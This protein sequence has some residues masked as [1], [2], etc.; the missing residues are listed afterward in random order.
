MGIRRWLAVC[1]LFLLACGGSA[2]RDWV[3]HHPDDPAEAPQVVV[4]A[5]TPP[6]PP[7][8]LEGEPF[9]VDTE[10]SFVSMTDPG[11]LPSLKVAT[12][13]GDQLLPLKH[14]HVTAHLLGFVASVQVEQ[15]YENPFDE[16]I[17]V[18]YVFPLPENSAVG[19]MEMHIGDRVIAA[20]IDERSR[21]RK[22]YEAAKRQ[23][24]TTALLEQ[25]RPNVFTQHVANIA[26]GEKIDVD[27]TYVQ[28]LSYDLGSYEFVF[29][30]VVG[31]RFMPGRTQPQPQTGTGTH[32]D[33][34]EVPDASRISP[35][36]LGRG[37]RSGHDI[38]IE[39]IA[40]AALPIISHSVP[41]HE[42]AARQPADGSLRLTLAEKESIPN[43]DF[44]LRYRVAGKQPLASLVTSG[45]DDDGYFALVIHP[46]AL[47]VDELVGR[48]ELIFVLDVSGSM[49]GRPLGLSKMAM[50]K[51]LA[52]L[53]PH[54]TFDIV[55]FAGS[56]RRLFKA[57]RPANRTNVAQALQF[58]DGLS[59]GGGT[60]MASAVQTALG[61]EVAPGRNRYVFFLTDGYVGNEDEIFRGSAELV[62]TLKERGQR[63]RVF[64]FG[65]GSSPNRHLL[66]GLSRAGEGIAVYASTRE[67]PADAVNRFYH[68]IDRPVL[69]GLDVRWGAFAGSEIFPDPLPDLFASH[70]IVLHGRYDKA[71]PDEVVVTARRGET[72]MSLPVRVHRVMA[73]REKGGVLGALWARSKIGHLSEVSWLEPR[74][75]TRE[76]ITALGLEYSLVTPYTSF[77][78]VDRSRV[79]GDGRPELMVQPVEVPEGVDGHAAGAVPGGLVAPQAVDISREE[80]VSDDAPM[81]GVEYSS[82]GCYCTTTGPEDGAPWRG[83]SILALAAALSLRLRSRRGRSRG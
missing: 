20:Q 80:A 18:V 6:P 30:M 72:E 61:S 8:P 66:E 29:P 23:G 34:D 36:V 22:T 28:D 5:D 26:P 13:D 75:D 47:D 2:T 69:T 42:V 46:P 19:A 70:P 43:R 55:T 39:V 67:D 53:R 37:Q 78:A 63:A 82:R 25:E 3:T 49:H 1:L 74:P 15:T 41:T 60:M 11:E 59:A 44:V 76:K 62:A 81:P 40:E 68:Y 57:P 16:P 50:L 73:P 31:P 38:S 17:E 7:V 32:P 52:G 33:T 45:E 64:G 83:M 54:D 58:V 71:L 10:R 56:S 27:I 48:R 51:A 79:V 4:A 21:A 65:V 77:V 14:T 24:H 35:P 9:V 12:S